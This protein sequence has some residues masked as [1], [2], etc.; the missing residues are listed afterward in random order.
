MSIS[1]EIEEKGLG[2]S[3]STTVIERIQNSEVNNV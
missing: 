1:K 3:N 2:E